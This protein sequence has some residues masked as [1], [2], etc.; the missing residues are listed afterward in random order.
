MTTKPFILLGLTTF[1][2]FFL[3]Y[4]AYLGNTD[5]AKTPDPLGPDWLARALDTR[6]TLWV[7]IATAFGAL[8]QLLE[9]LVLAHRA[10]KQTVQKILDEL[11]RDLLNN[12]PRNNRCTL[13]VAVWGWRALFHVLARLWW[14]DEKRKVLRDSLRLIIDPFGL[15]LYAYVRAMRSNNDRSCAIFKVYQN[16]LASSEGVAGMVW[17]EGFAA[18]SVKALP[19]RDERKLL[20]RFSTFDLFAA[21]H[22]VRRYATETNVARLCQ[23][24]ARNHLASHFVGQVVEAR[25]GNR[26]GVLLVDSLHE[27]CPFPGGGHDLAFKRNLRTYAQIISLLLT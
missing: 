20:D 10:R 1:T 17:A 3:A 14:Q 5:L 6:I 16:K 8:L 21:T 18:L 7:F 27:K 22:A 24:R 11:V 15:Y 9:K 23:L 26:W 12:D 19:T 2:L 4:L 25:D 13:F